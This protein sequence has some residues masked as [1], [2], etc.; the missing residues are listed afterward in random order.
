MAGEDD[1]AEALERQVAEMEALLAIFEGDEEVALEVTGLDDARARLEGDGGGDEPACLTL[2][3]TFPRESAD[4]LQLSSVR[5]R[6]PR[7]Y[8]S[9]AA[10]DV[11]LGSKFLVD[12]CQLEVDELLESE[13]GQE[14]LFQVVSIM[15]EAV[16]VTFAPARPAIHNQS[17]SGPS[18]PSPPLPLLTLLSASPLSLTYLRWTAAVLFLRRARGLAP[19]RAPAPAGAAWKAKWGKEGKMVAAALAET[20]GLP[21][22]AT[23]P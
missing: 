20:S 4:L 2:T 14:C 6:L 19:P 13:Q 8:P 16:Q 5:V 15:K 21:Q 12:A 10:P 18:S 23:F 3:L 1:A 11:N 17:N 22:S 9:S 7:G